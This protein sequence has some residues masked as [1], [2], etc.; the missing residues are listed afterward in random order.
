MSVYSPRPKINGVRSGAV[1]SPVHAERSSAARVRRASSNGNTA[2]Q[3]AEPAASNDV[4]GPIG[5]IFNRIL[6]LAENARGTAGMVCTKEQIHRYLDEELAFAERE[7]FRSQKLSG[8]AD[9]LVEQ[10][11]TDRDGLVSWPEFQVFQAQI[12]EM[13]APGA[14]GSSDVEAIAGAR[15]ASIDSEGDGVLDYGN[16]YDQAKADLP[17]GTK[18]SSLIAQLGAR[19]ALDA[20]DT[21]ERDKGVKKRGLGLEEWTDAARQ[22]SHARGD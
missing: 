15:F 12:L 22:L 8:V 1:D 17:E 14:T 16:L 10:L 19:I 6:G 2:V 7:M 3:R 21:N 9:K 18:H 11:D 20:V 5:R 13:L 4:V